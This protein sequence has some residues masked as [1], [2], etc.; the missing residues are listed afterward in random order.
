MT[1]RLRLALWYGGMTGAVVILVCA[2]S[3]A[4]GHAL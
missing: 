2:Y 4:A 3:H 1:L